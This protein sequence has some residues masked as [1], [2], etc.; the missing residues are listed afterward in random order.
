MMLGCLTIAV[1]LLGNVPAQGQGYDARD[2][3]G[4]WGKKEAAAPPWA[5]GESTMF[6]SEMPLQQ[7]AQEHCK[8]VGCGRGVNSEGAP[9]GN[10]YFQGSK[11]PVMS[12]C[13]PYGFPRILLNGGTT[14]IIHVPDRIF[15][16]FYMNNEMREIWTD[17]RGHP[18]DP[19]RPWTGHSTGKWDGNV[20]V[21]DTVGLIGGQ[22]GKFKWLDHAGYPHSDDLQVTERIQRTAA[23]LIEF[24]LTFNDSKTFT[25]PIRGRVLY[26]RRKDEK[27]LEITGPSVEYV[28]CEDR[29]YA[30]RENE[31]WPFFSG[32]YPVPQHPPAGPDR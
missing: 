5:R 2:F 10:A 22:D 12:R 4:Y 14:E 8:E 23:D 28:Q 20:L 6:A 21:V 15:M 9:R 27:A 1:V 24:N 13:A 29:I 16:R 26:E 18:E 3:S 25:A 17:G 32:D 19:Q 11:D 7:W 30:D 31:A